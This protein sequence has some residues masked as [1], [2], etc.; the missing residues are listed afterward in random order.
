MIDKDKIIQ[1]VQK[2]HHIT[3]HPDDPILALAAIND[4]LISQYCQDINQSVQ[5]V[6]QSYADAC[7]EIARDY[8]SVVRDNPNQKHS[9]SSEEVLKPI[10][11][12]M[13]S[14]KA[15]NTKWMII[16]LSGVLISL[17]STIFLVLK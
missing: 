8:A 14:M 3:L 17:V 7:A 15:Q 16:A 13:K 9:V 12:E 2:K 10:L 5:A 4:I 6:T 1:E 11:T